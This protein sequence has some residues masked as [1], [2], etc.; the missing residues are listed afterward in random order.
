MTN[1]LNNCYSWPALMFGSEPVVRSRLKR[2]VR[3]MWDSETWDALF[4]ETEMV[5]DDGVQ[6]VLI[7]PYE[8]EIPA[9][10]SAWRFYEL[11]RAIHNASAR[12][13]VGRL[14]RADRAKEVLCQGMNNLWFAIG[15]LN[16]EHLYTFDLLNRV[17]LPSLS[18]DLLDRFVAWIP[19]FEKLESRFFDQSALSRRLFD[20]NARE[21]A[22]QRC[23]PEESEVLLR[24]QK[25][26]TGP[27]WSYRVGELA[28]AA[29]W[30]FDGQELY[31]DNNGE[32]VR[33]ML[34]EGVIERV[35]DRY[36]VTEAFRSKTL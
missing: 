34:E 27:S 23:S 21:R 7:G 10:E 4:A 28:I 1:D 30:S 36:R 12:S 5:A 8:L 16:R 11:D 18:C 3:Q 6:D 20:H 25:L 15:M 13:K 32:I 22:R 14:E 35:S 31:V 19:E 17:E 26:T 29:G 9:A 33:V 24:C 2:F